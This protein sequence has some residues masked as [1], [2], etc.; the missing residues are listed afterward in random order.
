MPNKLVYL[1]LFG[2]KNKAFILLP[3]IYF[4]LKMLNRGRYYAAEKF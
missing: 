3:R 4:N 2:E 1:I